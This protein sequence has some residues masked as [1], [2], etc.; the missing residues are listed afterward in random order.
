MIAE[1]F[2]NEAP[3]TVGNFVSLIEQGFYNGLAFHRVLPGSHG[4]RRL[5][6]R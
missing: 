5:P 3:E 1:L 2:E 6:E 4:T